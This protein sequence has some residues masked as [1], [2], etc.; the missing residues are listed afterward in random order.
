M[1][2]GSGMISLDHYTEGSVF[3]GMI[4]A[5]EMADLSKALRAGSDINNPGATSG[6]G[7]P[8]RVESL[9]A[10]LHSTTLSQR[11]IVF[12][13]DVPKMPAFN[14]VEE[15]N[16]LTSVGNEEGLFIGEGELPE[17]DNSTYERIYT[18]IKYLGTLRRISH[19]ML[20]IKNALPEAILQAEAKAGTLK[21]LRGLESKLF[22]GDAT[23]SGVEFDGFFRKFIDGVA[24]VAASNAA[25]S[26]A[27]HGNL[28]TVLDTN[29]MQDL[30]Y[31]PMTEDTASDMVTYASDQPNHGEITDCYMPFNAY[32]DFSKQFYPK[33]RGQ[34][35][36]E[37][38]A[39][40]VVKSW[41]S[42]FGEVNLKP[43]K[44][45]HRSSLAGQTG[46]G[47]VLRR[48]AVPV[49]NT[50]TSPVLAG[51]LPGFGGTTQSRT[52]PAA[53]DGAGTY[54]YQIVAANKFGH[55]APV[56][57]AVAV[58]VGDMVTINV[59]DGSP[60]GTTEWYE[61]Y[62]SLPGAAA[63]TARFIFRMARSGAT[64]DIIDFN[65][66]LPGTSRMYWLQRNREAMAVKQ[67]LP[68]LKVNLAQI[69]LTV[70]FALILYL[71]LEVYC[72]RKHSVAINV[73]PLV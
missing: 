54:A 70:R 62:R 3:G 31:D 42:P 59:T 10:V 43:T 68:L 25:G 9:E 38:R 50:A 19:P 52:A 14:T 13:R 55:S 7:F 27:W 61:V 30:R 16:R 26:T 51:G 17:E 64:Q 33:E 24:A 44:Y 73:G 56:D 20:V 22:E 29:L 46:S 36:S 34:L 8:L 45:V 67:L 5:R 72:P 23:A 6:G 1:L 47:N 63:T 49:V 12:W 71:A 65:R 69:D 15:A 58:T 48:P 60:A 53:I 57:A 66:F 2:D 39:G 41:L 21:I 4:S 40:T 35:S 18:L 28:D 11:D 32:K 37:G